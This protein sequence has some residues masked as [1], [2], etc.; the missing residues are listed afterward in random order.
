M[1]SELLLKHFQTMRCKGS[2]KCKHGTSAAR[3]N[4]SSFRV[5][6][7]YTIWSG[8]ALNQAEKDWVTGDTSPQKCSVCKVSLWYLWGLNIRLWNKTRKHVVQIITPSSVSKILAMPR[9]GKGSLSQSAI[10]ET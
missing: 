10:E 3:Q 4:R 2:Y 8:G 6:I 7:S 1:L 9:Y 5:R